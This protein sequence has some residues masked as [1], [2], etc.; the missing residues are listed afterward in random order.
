M[1]EKNDFELDVKEKQK[2]LSE[3]ADHHEANYQTQQEDYDRKIREKKIELEEV[4]EKFNKI[5][6][7]RL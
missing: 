4:T 2:F 5:E 1:K 6:E 3:M 7:F